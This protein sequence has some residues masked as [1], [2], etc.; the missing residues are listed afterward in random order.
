MGKRKKGKDGQCTYD[1]TMI[2][3]PVTIVVAEKQ[4][5]ITEPV[6]RHL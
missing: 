6:C 4:P 1:A 2:S 5:S 3:F